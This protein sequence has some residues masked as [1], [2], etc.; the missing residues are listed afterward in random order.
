MGSR[1]LLIATVLAFAVP[2]A[3]ADDPAPAASAQKSSASA[4]ASRQPLDLS[5]P[6]FHKVMPAKELEANLNAPDDEDDDADDNPPPTVDVKGQ[7][8][9]PVVPGGIASIWWGI[10]HPTELWRIFAP[11]Q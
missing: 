1:A 5:T 2:A 10:T 4:S 8:P 6:D 7:H 9:A 11:I 3:W